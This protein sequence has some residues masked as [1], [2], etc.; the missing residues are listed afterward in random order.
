MVTSR[1]L[2]GGL[3]ALLAVCTATGQECARDV[4]AVPAAKTARISGE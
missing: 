2:A 3:C 1:V 4:P